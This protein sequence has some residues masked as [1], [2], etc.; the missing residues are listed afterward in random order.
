MKKTSFI[1]FVIFLI[2]SS[3][4]EVPDLVLE[5]RIPGIH[6]TTVDLVALVPLSSGNTYQINTVLIHSDSFVI[7]GKVKNPHLFYLSI[8]ADSL[9]RTSDLF[10][11]IHASMILR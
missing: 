3:K 10:S 5:G 2:N 4:A 9:N 7:Y 11:W 8:K 6:L 1:L